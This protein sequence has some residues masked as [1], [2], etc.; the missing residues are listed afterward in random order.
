[1]PTKIQ[2][3]IGI[4]GLVAIVAVPAIFAMPAKAGFECRSTRNAIT[5]TVVTRCY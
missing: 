2:I 3:I 5:G 1:M 4:L